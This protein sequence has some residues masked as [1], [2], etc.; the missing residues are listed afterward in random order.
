MVCRFF[1]LAGAFATALVMATAPQTAHA[2]GYWN[3]P[4]N[5]CQSWGYGWGAGHHA[6]LTLGPIT[7]EGLCAHNEVRLPCAPQP[8]YA[9]Y[10]DPGYNFDFRQP[11]HTVTYE[12]P[13]G[14]V[15]YGPNQ[16]QPQPHPQQYLGESPPRGVP[17]L[18][19]DSL[20]IPDE[21]LPDMPD[22]KREIFGPPVE[23]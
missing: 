8:P 9:C 13:T 23:P 19:P 4:G 22:V 14:P 11:A 6:C 1:R 21:A 15:E 12:Q 16:P 5:F 7:H 20:P 17:E 18:A 2:I 3:M 10:S